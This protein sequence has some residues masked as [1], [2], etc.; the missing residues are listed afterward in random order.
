MALDIEKFTETE[1]RAN[2]ASKLNKL[3][4]ALGSLT[5]PGI[6]DVTGLQA[7]LDD[8][9]SADALASKADASALAGKADTNHTHGIADVTG[10]Q[11]ALDALAD[12]IAALE[13]PSAG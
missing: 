3:K 6:A 13:E 10:L 12:R 11:D 1:T 7:A 9:A 5:T 4:S 8:K 2:Q